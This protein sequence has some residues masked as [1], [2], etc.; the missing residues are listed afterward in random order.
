VDVPCVR[1]MTI[2]TADDYV[3]SYYPPLTPFRLGRI[4]PR[5]GIDERRTVVVDQ[6]PAC[7][8]VVKRPAAVSIVVGPRQ[9]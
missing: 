6:D 8:A 3:R 4:E 7:G 9:P 5:T 1:G 2:G